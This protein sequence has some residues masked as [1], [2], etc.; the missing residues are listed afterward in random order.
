MSYI[1]KGGEEN[2]GVLPEGLEQKM[3][4]VPWGRTQ[5]LDRSCILA[6]QLMYRRALHFKCRMESILKAIN[7]SKKL[8]LT[9]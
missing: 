5:E 8:E 9:V 4:R 1:G 6:T 7:L 2:E 3:G